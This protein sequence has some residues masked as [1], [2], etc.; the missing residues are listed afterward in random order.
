MYE[1]ENCGIS[2]GF[3]ILYKTNLYMVYHPH[4]NIISFDSM[5]KENQGIK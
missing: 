5:V 1:D 4:L 3:T 2:A